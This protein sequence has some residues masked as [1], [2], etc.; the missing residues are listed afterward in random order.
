MSIS[1]FLLRVGLLQIGIILKY[2]KGRCHQ[3]SEE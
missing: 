1:E 2:K 3:V